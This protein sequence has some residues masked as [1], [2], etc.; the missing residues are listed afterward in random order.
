MREIGCGLSEVCLAVWCGLGR[1]NLNKWSEYLLR[2]ALE[3][4]KRRPEKPEAP[5]SGPLLWACLLLSL[6]AHLSDFL[7][8]HSL[9]SI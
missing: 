9:H 8:L 2:Q 5:D 6:G 3:G 4:P 7:R 1:E